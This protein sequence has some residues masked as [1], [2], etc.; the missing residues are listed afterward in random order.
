M[1]ICALD[2]G[3]VEDTVYFEERWWKIPHGVKGWSSLN[4]QLPAQDCEIVLE[5][6]CA[7][8]EIF[9]EERPLYSLDPGRSA[10]I[11]KALQE[12]KDDASDARTL[13]QLRQIRPDL[14]KR[15]EVRSPALQRLRD[16]V[17]VRRTLV[18][19]QTQ[20]LQ[21]LQAVGHRGKQPEKKWLQGFKGSPLEGLV[22]VLQAVREQLAR[23]EA[24][25]DREG[26]QVSACATLRSIQ[27]MGSNLSAE[28][29]AE[30]D[31]FEPF[32]DGRQAQAYAGTAPVTLKSGLSTKVR[33]RYRCNHRARNA[34][35]LFAFCSMRFHRWARDFYDAARQRGKT[36][37]SALLALAN[38][39]VPILLAMV[40]N[41]TPYDPTR[42][43]A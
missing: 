41:G 3:Q 18:E 28:I 15:I 14:Y 27:G 36:H 30:L 4:E 10:Q 32:Q 8:L 2:L 16:L 19:Q 33:I 39:W 22:C 23:I 35:Y 13:L 20:L 40:K 6:R 42:R 7:A 31:A 11:R 34:L 29:T 9:F 43:T 21:Q 26:G 5:G 17:R 37:S 25:I 12:P 1:K 38:R 24:H